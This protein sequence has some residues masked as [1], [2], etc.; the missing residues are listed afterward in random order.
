MLTAL[1]NFA[2]Y[3]GS[4]IGLTIGFLV[5]YAALTRHPEFALVRAGNVAAA[6]SLGGAGIGFALPLAS[7]ISHSAG[8]LDM[9]VWAVVALIVQSVLYLVLRLIWR[10]LSDQIDN[11]SLAHAITLASFAIIVGILNAASMTY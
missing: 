3:F 4:A 2:L 10:D 9:V 5:V 6:I 1:A 8:W 11:G 7:V